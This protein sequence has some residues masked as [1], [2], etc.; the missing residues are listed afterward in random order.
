MSYFSNADGAFPMFDH[1]LEPAFTMPTS[2]FPIPSHDSSNR[3]TTTSM[4]ESRNIRPLASDFHTAQA[5]NSTSLHPPGSNP[6]SDFRTNQHS[7]YQVPSTAPQQSPE[8]RA[9]S[10]DQ[11]D[12]E[13]INSSSNNSNNT[14]PASSNPTDSEVTKHKD[15]MSA[16]HIASNRGHTAVLSILLSHNLD[17]NEPDGS[18]RSP[19]HLAAI[20]GHTAVISLLLSHGA[21]VNAT[22]SL[23]R[24]ALHWAV[25][26]GH[27][28]VIKMFLD[29]GGADLNLRDH[30]D[31][32][33][34]HVAVE[35]GCEGTLR[36]LLGH[37]ADLSLKARKCEW[38]KKEEKEV[39]DESRE[40]RMVTEE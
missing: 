37:G 38:W 15:S 3:S 6:Q 34:L 4:T 19:L 29:T 24:T 22:D 27:E 32:S 14:S 7:Q 9:N 2:A 26:R 25:L 5:S 12:S 21:R 1:N 39:E 23:G 10:P 11:P 17:P 8:S 33:V 30:N 31:W 20:N 35:R 18:G 36:M 13:S 28:A 40:E 16:L